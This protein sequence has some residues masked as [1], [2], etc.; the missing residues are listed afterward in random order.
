MYNGKILQVFFECTNLLDFLHDIVSIILVLNI[1]NAKP[2]TEASIH[3][4]P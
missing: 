2:N 1:R 3:R 4:V